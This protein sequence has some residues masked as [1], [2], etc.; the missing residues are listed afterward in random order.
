[1]RFMV[2]VKADKDSEAGA[3]PDEKLLTEM[4]K[5]NEELV[6]GRRDAGRRG[7]AAELE[8][9]PGSSSPARSGRS[10]TGR[11]PKPRS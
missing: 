9:A 11:S 4:G 3:L 5:Y 2:I 7:A 1:M 8:R 6:E 10:S